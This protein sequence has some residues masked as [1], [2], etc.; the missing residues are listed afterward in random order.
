MAKKGADAGVHPFSLARQTDQLAGGAGSLRVSTISNGSLTT[1][2]RGGRER[3]GRGA[4]GA[5]SA[6]G[7][8]GRRAVSTS[9]SPESGGKVSAI[10]GIS[11][12]G[13]RAAAR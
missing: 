4:S 1:T 9:S 6:T 13:A 2:A 11:G 7:A 8:A 3:L 5:A 10:G 12:K